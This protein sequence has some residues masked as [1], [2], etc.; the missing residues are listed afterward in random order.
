MLDYL[1][2]NFD[3]TDIL[4]FNYNVANGVLTVHGKDELGR[5]AVRTQTLSRLDAA[6]LFR[7]YVSNLP[8]VG[9]SG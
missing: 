6:R 9:I 4:S 7:L 8:G 5:L 1:K 2:A 3:L